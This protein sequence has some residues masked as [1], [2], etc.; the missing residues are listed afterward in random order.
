MRK[1]ILC[2]VDRWVWDL[3]VTLGMV[4]QWDLMGEWIPGSKWILDYKW[5]LGSRW[6]QDSKWHQGW[7]WGL[8]D[9]CPCQWEGLAQEVPWIQCRDLAPV[10][11]TVQIVLMEVH[12]APHKVDIS[13]WV[14]LLTQAAPWVTPVAIPAQLL[15]DTLAPA[16]PT[17]L[18]P[19]Q[20]NL[21][22][23]LGHPVP[24]LAT[25]LLEDLALHTLDMGAGKLRL[26]QAWEDLI[27]T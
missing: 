21:A 8:M 25:L 5:I 18:P 3:M 14:H 6:I 4:V 16:R 10:D 17:P 13:H 27:P 2:V 22:M 11:P 1:W 15:V 12:Q 9:R 20:H 19:A 24:V 26:T 7:L 23:G